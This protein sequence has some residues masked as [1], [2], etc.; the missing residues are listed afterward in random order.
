[1][2]MNRKNASTYQRLTQIAAFVAE[3]VGLF[4]KTSA[5]AEV[6]KALESGVKILGEQ[7]AAIVSADTATRVAKTERRTA[8]ATLKAVLT[9]AAKLAATYDVEL[10]QPPARATERSL[11]DCGRAF[12][13]DALTLRKEFAQHGVGVETVTDA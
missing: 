3:K 9:R 10:L 7:S 4:P 11:I 12:E 5:A 13:A 1:M 8:R 2:T 6:Q